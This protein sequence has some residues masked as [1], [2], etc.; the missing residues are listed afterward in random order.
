[1]DEIYTPKRQAYIIEFIKE[2]AIV[3]SNI[4]MNSLKISSLG[5]MV[6]SHFVVLD[7]SLSNLF[8]SKSSC[9][10]FLSLFSHYKM[11]VHSAP[12]FF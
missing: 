8:R 4:C 2:V 11:G 5:V 10:F 12:Y 1:M 3:Y 7:D 6:N 9:C